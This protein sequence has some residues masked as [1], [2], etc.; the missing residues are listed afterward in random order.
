MLKKF[1]LFIWIVGTLNVSK[2]KRNGWVHKLENKGM[3]S[4][5]QFF[6][7]LLCSWYLETIFSLFCRT[8]SVLLITRIYRVFGWTNYTLCV[9]EG[10]FR[11]M[12]LFSYSPEWKLKQNLSIFI[13]FVILRND[14]VV[15]LLVVVINC[16]AFSRCSIYKSWLDY[17]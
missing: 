16:L 1:I 13:N 10:R 7:L 9:V 14:V 5:F 17:V 6:I 2:Q 8:T 3:G 4:I 12:N 11:I 15:S